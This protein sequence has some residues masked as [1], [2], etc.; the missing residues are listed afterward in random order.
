MLNGGGGEI[1]RNF[2]HLRDARFTV[3]ALLWSFYSQF[4]PRVCTGR[5]SEREYHRQ[6]AEKM[7]QTLGITRDRLYRHE[8][9][10]LYPLFRCRFWMGQNN[11]INNRLGYALTPFIDH[12]IVRDAVTVPVKYKNF[13][14]LEA[15]LI[16]TVDPRLAA[17]SSSYGHDFLHDPP[18]KRTVKDLGMHLRPCWLRRR[19]YRLRS[20]LRPGPKSM[21]SPAR[22]CGTALKEDFPYMRHWFHIRA[23]RDPQQF[24][25]ICTLAYL[26]QKL[27]P[28][29]ADPEKSAPCRKA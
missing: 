16:R 20:R 21:L 7:K 8:I 15:R 14:R 17:Y 5:F 6:L 23:I 26:F 25:R 28:D 29:V 10:L 12:T 18:R 4:D 9:E 24:N 1:F 11:S 3:E 13:G 22:D 27:R 2:F 19:I